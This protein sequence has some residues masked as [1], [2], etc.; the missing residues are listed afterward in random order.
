MEP[1]QTQ[2]PSN[3]KSLESSKPS[4][5]I[6]IILLTSS[7]KLQ[8]RQSTHTDNLAKLRRRL[9]FL[10]I[11]TRAS[12]SSGLL[13]HCRSFAY[14]SRLPPVLSSRRDPSAQTVVYARVEF[15][16]TGAHC[17]AHCFLEATRLE[18]VA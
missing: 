4:T 16:F 2:T 3:Q 13:L 18:L 15:L 6:I 1:A 7:I 12:R 17:A 9:F 11:R 10:L 14:V 8:L 5:V